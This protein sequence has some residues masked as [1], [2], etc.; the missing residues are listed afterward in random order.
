MIE[1]GGK[2]CEGQHEDNDRYE[3]NDLKQ[4]KKKC[5]IISRSQNCY[6]D[7]GAYSFVCTCKYYWQN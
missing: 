7:H 4:K 1:N 2:A 3:L 5:N 6:I